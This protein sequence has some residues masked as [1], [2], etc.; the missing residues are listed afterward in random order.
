MF[1]ESNHLG[2][3]DYLKIERNENFSFAS[4][5]HLCFEIIIILRG[6]MEVTVNN[7]VFELRKNQAVLIFPNQIHSLSS[8]DSEHILCIFSPDLIKAFANKVSNKIPVDN[9]F[10]PDEYLI[11]LLCD[12]NSDSSISEKKGL[13]YSLC[14]QFD[15][16]ADYIENQKH[17][18]NLLFKI[19]AF[20]ENHFGA[21]CSLEALSKKTGYNYSYLSRFF[22]NAVGISFNKYVLYYRLSHACYLLENSDYSIINCAI[23]SGF[24]SIRTFNRNFKLPYGITPQDYIINL[25]FKG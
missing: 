11:N 13:L 24:D 16:A 14:G 6:K 9:K 19:F 25:R 22:T 4:H 5:L 7:K 21:D 8:R 1:Y 12:L 10:F 3:P 18:D 2:S 17:K 15:K 23:E 20:V